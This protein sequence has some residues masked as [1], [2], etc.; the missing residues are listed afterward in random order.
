MN[1]TAD[2]L[3]PVSGDPRTVIHGNDEHDW[4]RETQ[5]VTMTRAHVVLPD[6]REKLTVAVVEARDE[7]FEADVYY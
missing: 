6:G 1:G 3:D 7:A 5:S 2:D 4:L